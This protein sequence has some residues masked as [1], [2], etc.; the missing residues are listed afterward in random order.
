MFVR[1]VDTA[2]VTSALICCIALDAI[3]SYAIKDGGAALFGGLGAV[4]L[5][6][7]ADGLRLQLARR[8]S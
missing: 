4:N 8:Q 6:T 2:L 1:T 3:Q 7:S 5:G